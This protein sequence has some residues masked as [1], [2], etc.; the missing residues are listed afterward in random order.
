MTRRIALTTMLMSLGIL[1][2]M[3]AYVA[4]AAENSR[5]PNIVL[6]LADDLGYADLG[7]YG[8]TEIRTPHIDR[9]AAEGMRFTRFYAGASVCAPSRCVLM[10]GKHTGHCRVRGNAPLVERARQTLTQDDLTV[11]ALLKRAGYATALV[12]KWGLGMD[13]MPGQPLRQGFDFFFGYLDQVHAHN[14]FPDYVWPAL[15]EKTAHTALAYKW[16]FRH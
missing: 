3:V 13:D 2:G 4:R 1:T 6:I 9:L 7:C 8:Q 10:T 11:A 16:L 12:G 5:K 15:S 14:Y